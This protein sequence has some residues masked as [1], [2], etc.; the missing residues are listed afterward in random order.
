MVTGP[1]RTA[2]CRSTGSRFQELPGHHVIFIPH[3]SGHLQCQ[4]RRPVT[5]MQEHTK[6]GQG[7]QTSV[8]MTVM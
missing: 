6:I 2:A 4:V 5:H 1:A 8:W 7:G 3:K